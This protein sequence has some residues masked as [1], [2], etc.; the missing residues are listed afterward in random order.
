MK[1][2]TCCWIVCVLFAVLL[3]EEIFITIHPDGALFFW[4]IV[5]PI[6]AGTSLTAGIAAIYFSH[7]KSGPNPNLHGITGKSVAAALLLMILFLF[8]STS[9]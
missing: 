4:M 3:L 5:V 7:R 2:V 9:G 1:L 8:L 6:T